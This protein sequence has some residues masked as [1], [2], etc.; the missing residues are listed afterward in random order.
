M[1]RT[2]IK[3]MVGWSLAI[4]LLMPMACLGAERPFSAPLPAACAPTRPPGTLHAR[5]RAAAANAPLAMPPARGRGRQPHGAGRAGRAR[6]LG[7]LRQGRRRHHRRA[8]S[9][10]SMPPSRTDRA[11][12]KLIKEEKSA[13]ADLGAAGRQL[14]RACR[15]RARHRGQAG[16]AA[17]R[18][19]VHEIFESAG[20]RPADRRPRRQRAHPAGP[21]LVRRLQRQPVRAGRPPA[22]RRARA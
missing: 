16:D 6:R 19:T 4:A 3:S 8:G 9:G 15:L 13:G 7:A 12:F 11:C 14:Y 21:D 22:D 2:Y 20:R 10:A 17:R 18:P 5:Q 1:S